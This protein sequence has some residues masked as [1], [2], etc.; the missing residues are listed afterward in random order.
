MANA[1]QNKTGMDAWKDSIK[2]LPFG[3]VSVHDERLKRQEGDNRAYLMELTTRNLLYNYEL[4]A[5]ITH[6][7]NIPDRKSTRLNSSHP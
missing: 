5:A 4:E 7:A 6:D 1:E 2:A 3:K